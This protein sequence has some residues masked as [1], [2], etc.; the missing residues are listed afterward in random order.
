[1]RTSQNSIEHVLHAHSRAITDINFSAHHPDLLA[2]CAVDSFVHCWDLRTPARPVVSFSDWFTGAT[3][4]K[5]NRQDP[6]VIASSHDK[7]LHI[8]DDRK[9]AYP[10]RTFEAHGT[11]IYGIDWNRTRPEAIVTCAL[12]KTI[13]FWNYSKEGSK[14]ENV[15][16]TPFPVW[17]TRHTPFG[18]CLLYTSPSPRD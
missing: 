1:M 14:P 10:L 5:W 11:K 6:H 16:H 7:S 12:D 2:T 4:V 13:K 3:Q 8:W 18:C 15:T 17:R 9:G